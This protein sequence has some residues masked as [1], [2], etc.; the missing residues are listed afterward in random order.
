MKYRCVLCVLL[1]ACLEHSQL[2]EASE[3]RRPYNYGL[4]CQGY[5]SKIST[6]RNYTN[7]IFEVAFSHTFLPFLEQDFI[8]CTVVEVDVQS[9]NKQVMRRCHLSQIVGIFSYL[10][11]KLL[12]DLCVELPC[13]LREEVNPSQKVGFGAQVLFMELV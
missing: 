12:H 10:P 11:E 3:N 13:K 5:L 6:Y 2:M 9:E 4:F 1:R 7:S 8:G